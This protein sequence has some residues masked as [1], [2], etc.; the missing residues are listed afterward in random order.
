M[1]LKRALYQDNDGCNC[2]A[3]S[4]VGTLPFAVAG[5]LTATGCLNGLRDEIVGRF[6]LHPAYIQ[7]QI[8]DAARRVSNERPS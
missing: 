2:E 3:S 8:D 1:L 7:G 6:H 5:V 4:L